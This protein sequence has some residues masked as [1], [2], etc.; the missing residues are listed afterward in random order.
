MAP[1]R[2]AE[3]VEID[4]RGQ[5]AQIL[6]KSVANVGHVRKTDEEVPRISVIDVA[7]G[8]TGK[9]AQAAAKDVSIM[10]TRYPEVC[11]KL[12]H[13][14]FPGA[15]QRETHV[16]DIP[17]IIE[18]IFLLPGQ[19]AAQV[20]S[21][22]SKLFVRYLGG[23][24]SLVQEVRQMA[25]I[26]KHLGEEAPENPLC[27]FAAAAGSMRSHLAAVTAIDAIDQTGYSNDP[28]KLLQ[29]GK[30]LAGP[31]G[32][33]AM[34]KQIKLGEF[35]RS[36][37][38]PSQYRVANSI[39]GQ[40][41]RKMLKSKLEVGEELFLH[42][43]MGR[44]RVTYFEEDRPLM[45]RILGDMSDQINECRLALAESAREFLSELVVSL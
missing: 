31:E 13:F 5:L 41:S 40:F 19:M 29:R 16:A 24:L 7:R 12:T 44:P 17:T 11:Q 23:D 1:K 45:M 43:N 6:G 37:F 20:R 4:I 39:L 42:M 22:A 27:L 2:K 10:I 14:K 25:H 32:R 26:Q 3:E 38:P 9:N 30:L 15:G 36:Q 28:Y 8:I 34:A 33:L 21:E 18:V 35:L